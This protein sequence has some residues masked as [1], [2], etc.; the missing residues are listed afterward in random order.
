MVSRANSGAGQPPG[1]VPSAGGPLITL[2][3]RLRFRSLGYRGLA[4]HPR[5][6]PHDNR[7]EGR[8]GCLSSESGKLGD[9][10]GTCAAGPSLRMAVCDGWGEADAIQTLGICKSLEE[11]CGH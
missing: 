10:S 3:P 11:Q 1:A 8:T 7:K 9:R 4:P 5:L 6:Q 2:W